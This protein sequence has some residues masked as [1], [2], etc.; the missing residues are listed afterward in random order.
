MYRPADRT[1][2]SSNHGQNNQ[3]LN[4]EYANANVVHL[5][6]H[7]SIHQHLEIALLNY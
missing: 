4:F 1:G 5:Q 3:G 2:S 7:E 6:L